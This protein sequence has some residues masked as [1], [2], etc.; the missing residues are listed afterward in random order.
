MPSKRPSQHSSNDTSET[1]SI[2]HDSIEHK[3]RSGEAS[4]G[5]GQ[6]DRWAWAH[7]KPC[8]AFTPG[9]LAPKTCAL[10]VGF[11]TATTVVMGHARLG[12]EAASCERAEVFVGLRSGDKGTQLYDCTTAM[13]Q[14]Q[15]ILKGIR[16]RDISR[17]L[18]VGVV[19]CCG[20]GGG[21]RLHGN[22]L[23]CVGAKSWICPTHVHGREDSCG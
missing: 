9:V 5:S 18:M 19:F 22:T 20:D 13:S 8:R 10:G 2:H 15:A 12:L 17:E 23:D 4:A 16:T 21:K 7:V 14:D 3:Q 6:R 1:S 11:D